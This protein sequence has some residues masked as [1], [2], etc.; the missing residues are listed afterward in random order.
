VT[1]PTRPSTYLNW[2]PSGNPAY[3]TQPTTGQAATGWVE[4]EAPPFQYWNWLEYTTDQWLIWLDYVTQGGAA[5]TSAAVIVLVTTGNTT[6][7]SNQLTTLA[8]TTGV[9]AGHAVSGTG[10]ASGTYVVEISGST[11]TMSRPATASGT[12]TAVTFS[13]EYA[14]GT[15]VQAQ[16]DELDAAASRNR[17]YDLVVGSGAQCDYATLNALVADTTIGP[18]KRILLIESQT[19]N[20]TVNFTQNYWAIEAIPGITLTNGTAGTGL[21]ASAQGL[22]FQ[23]LRFV[24]FTTAISFQSAGTYGRVLFCWFNTCTTLVDTSSASPGK[25]PEVIGNISE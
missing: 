22:T 3:I 11:V 21:E 14:T 5:T 23:N 8:A 10:I 24:G 9:L 20:T 17:P 13:H 15:T 1:T 6:S 12:T 4:L 25:L 19:L 18:N 16:L 2:V 7:G